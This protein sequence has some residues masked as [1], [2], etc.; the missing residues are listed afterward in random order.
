MATE[1]LFAHALAY[2]AGGF[3]VLPLHSPDGGACTC[4][5]PGCDSPAKHPRTANGLTDAT[6]DEETIRRWWT[7]WPEANVGIAVPDSHVVVDV[8][9]V[10]A[11]SALDGRELPTTATART[12]RG[13]QF[14]YRTMRPVRPTVGALPHVDI[15]GVGSYVVAPPSQHVNG[16]EY[17]W[18]APPKDG[19]AEAPGW[20]YD[21]APARRLEP[22]DV[23][24]PIPSGQRNAELTRR[25]GKLRR[26]GF[27]ESTILPRS[28]T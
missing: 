7:M 6:T 12:G 19:I 20:V 18:I 14:L 4:R 13:W 15:R 24:A 9:V 26:D 28:E 17:L 27:S 5:R 2:A 23:G 16:A 22:S 11:T 3:P 21:V 10:E 8:D 25:A 1:K